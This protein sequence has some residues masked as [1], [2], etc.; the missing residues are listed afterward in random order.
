[1]R[2]KWVTRLSAAEAAAAA[3]TTRYVRCFVRGGK[4]YLRYLHQVRGVASLSSGHLQ[5]PAV[6][7][8]CILLHSQK[9]GYSFLH[10]GLILLRMAWQFLLRSSH[11]I[12]G[13][14]FKVMYC[15][16]VVG[17]LAWPYPCS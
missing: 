2:K 13:P 16:T 12:C 9:L 8:S 11:S 3:K 6:L 4:V 17:C 5:Y 14:V 15:R 7:L 1:M 10:I